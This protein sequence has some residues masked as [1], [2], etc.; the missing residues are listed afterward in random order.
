[1]LL[2][3]LL[4]GAT[5]AGYSLRPWKHE[6]AAAPKAA[7][8]L[9]DEDVV[10]VQSGLFP[11]VGYDDRFRL[12]T[13]ETLDDPRHAG[14]VVLLTPRLGAYPFS[15]RSLTESL[16]GRSPNGEMPDGLLA[17]RLPEGPGGCPPGEGE[18]LSGKIRRT[19]RRTRC[20]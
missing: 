1:V 6:T 17:V 15:A 18:P 2:G 16:A 13:P 4:A 7:R 10:L 14:A 19:T 5:R 8:R 20:R 9:H 12:L 3:A 11:H